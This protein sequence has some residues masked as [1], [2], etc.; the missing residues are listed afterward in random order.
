MV[1]TSHRSLA[2]SHTRAIRSAAPATSPCGAIPTLT[3]VEIA[4]GLKLVGRNRRMVPADYAGARAA[5]SLVDIEDP[6]VRG[7]ALWFAP[8]HDG[9][10]SSGCI[11]PANRVS[12][13]L[14]YGRSELGSRSD[15]GPGPTHFDSLLGDVLRE[16][17]IPDLLERP[18]VPISTAPERELPLPNPVGKLDAG[19][20]NGR[21]PERLEAC[22]RGAPAFDRPMIL[23]NEIV[24][25]LATPHLN[26]LPLR[27][28]PP[29]KPK[30]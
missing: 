24:E 20:C 29:Q 22:H 15:S 18:E 11:G 30:S 8:L 26:V 12:E 27:V 13:L 3:P 23:L 9:V 16:C 28:L 17:S 6:A 1:V 10:I 21:T 5:R 7:S 2:Q 25:V 19:Q 14:H 4:D